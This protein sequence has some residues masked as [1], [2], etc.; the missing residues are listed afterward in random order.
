MCYLVEGWGG[1]MMKKRSR[2]REAFWGSAWM[3]SPFSRVHL[4]ATPWTTAR[5][6]PL[7]VGF[8]RREY[9]SGL[10]FPWAWVLLFYT[11]LSGCSHMPCPVQIKL[12]KIFLLIRNY[13]PRK[14]KRKTSLCETTGRGRSVKLRVN[15][16]HFFLK[17]FKN[18]VW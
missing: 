16:T 3:L 6:A 8:S 14:E 10:P 13:C 11:D 18:R 15:K 1:V 9:W 12:L 7:S 5:W 4:F 2:V 17:K